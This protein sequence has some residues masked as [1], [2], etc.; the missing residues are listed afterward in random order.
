[1]VV[2]QD[3]IISEQRL[4]K[5]QKLIMETLEA[6][7]TLSTGNQTLIISP[8]DTYPE[9]VETFRL[10]LDG[11]GIRGKTITWGLIFTSN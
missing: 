10:E 5:F 8:D 6:D 7:I 2:E 11:Q 9:R 4:D 3:S 1:M